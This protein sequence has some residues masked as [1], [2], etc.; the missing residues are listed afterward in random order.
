MK[1]SHLSL[2]NKKSHIFLLV[3]LIGSLLVLGGYFYYNHSAKILQQEKENELKAIAELKINQIVDWHKER[4]ADAKVISQSPFIID[5]IK[6]W[7]KNQNNK[8]LENEISIKLQAPQKEFGYEAIFLSSTAGKVLLTVGTGLEQFENINGKKI[9]ESVEKKKITFTDFYYCDIHQKIHNDLVTPLVD[10]TGKVIAVL[11]FRTDPSN[12]I[13]P[14]IQEWPIPS[15]SAETFLVKKDGDSV[16]SLSERRFYKNVALKLR[17]PLNKTEIPLVQAVLGTKG[18]YEGRSLMGIDVLSYLSPVPGTN[19]YLIAQID[20]NEMLAELKFRGISVIIFLVVLISSLTIGLVWIY[21]YR[22][23]NIYRTL[24][25]TQQEYKTTIHSIGDAVITTDKEGRVRFLNPVAEKLTGWSET[26]AFGKPLH[27][28]FNII[29]EVTRNKVENPVKK[30]LETGLIVGLANHTILISKDGNEIPITDS[31]APIRTESGEIF[32]VVL[33]FSDQT[34]ERLSRKILDIRLQLFEYAASH[35]LVELLT[36]TLDEVESL[37]KSQIGFFHFVDPDQETLSLQAWS[38]GTKNV[39]CKAAGEGLHYKISEA[40]VWVECV[41]QKK[42]VIHNDYAS[43]P[44]KKGLPE[45]HSPIVRELVV[46]ILRGDN[47]VA[48]LGMGNK[49]TEYIDKDVEIVNYFAD[50]CWEIVEQKRGAENIFHKNQILSAI[51]RAHDQFISTNGIKEVFDGLLSD[52]LSITKSG[53]GFIGEVLFNGEG[54]PY[55][56][57]HAISNISWNE[58]TQKFY[59]ENAAKGMEFYNLKTLFGEALETG[60]TLIANDPPNHPKRG[61]LPEGHPPLNSFLG[62]PI[63]SGG[64]LVAM[65][66]IANAPGGYTSEIIGYL[67]P[68]LGTIGQL[69]ETHHNVAKRKKAESALRE[70]E[71]KLRNIFEHSTNLFYSHDT[72]YNLQYFSPQVKDILGY[73]AE[74]AK[75]NWTEIIS[76][77]PINKIGFEKT[78]KA[79]ETGIQQE[80]YE[81]ELIHK[82]GHKVYVEVRE[83][84]VVENGKTVAIVGSLTDITERKKAQLKIDESEKRFRNVVEN[85]HEALIV[86]NT[87]GRV[88]YANNEFSNIFGYSKE[89]FLDLTSK[90]YTA[91]AS[92]EEVIERHRKRMSGVAV[93]EKFVYKGK[94][95]DGTEIWIEARVTELK[96]NGQIVGTQS[97]ERDITARKHAE[98]ELRTKLKNEQS[99]TSITVKAISVENLQQFLDNCIE[100]IGKSLEVDRVYLF[101]HRY[102][103]DTMDNTHEWCAE[104]ILPQ[105]E[106]LQGIPSI[107]VPWWMEQMRNNKLINFEDI[108]YLPDEGAK[109]SLREQGIRSIL[110]VPLYV[111]G[112]YFGFIGFDECK[113]NRKW[114]DSMI[115]FLQS[116]S[117][118]MMNV[119]ER[120]WAGEELKRSREQYERFFMEDLTG[121]FIFTHDG[122]ILTCNPSF[123]KIFGFTSMEEA[124]NINSISLFRSPQESEKLMS[125]LQRE[126]KLELYD[127]EMV[128]KDGTPL[129]IVANLLGYFDESD[130]LREVQGYVFDDTKRRKLE[131]TLIHTQKMESIG[132]LAGGIAHDFNNILGI[133][134]GHSSLLETNMNN[135]EKLLKC[136]DAINT[137]SVRGASLVK[138]LLTIARKSDTIVGTVQVNDIILEIKKLACET[139]SKTIEFDT[140]LD[141]QIPAIDADATQIHQVMINLCVNARDAMPSGGKLAISTSKVPGDI[142][143]QMYPQAIARDYVSIFVKDTGLGMPEDVRKRIF[144]PFFTTKGIGKGTGLGLS[145]VHSIIESHRGLIEVSSELGKGTEFHIYFPI[146]EKMMELKAEKQKIDEK[147]YEGDET[148]LII[149]D[150]ELLRELLKTILTRAGYQVLIAQDG[151]EGI[152]LY[153]NHQQNID[154][155]ISDLGLPKLAGDEVFRR[156]KKLHQNIKFILASGFIDKNLKSELYKSGVKCIIQKPFTAVE[157]LQ[158]IREV[159]D[160]KT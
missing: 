21:H 115:T 35:S 150:E 134:L 103:T 55:L 1:Q 104:G 15:K 97:L 62:L 120:N 14:L 19:W 49:S 50:V 45:G 40:G 42:P 125:R 17:V 66:G 24:W 107:A 54:Q 109:T 27:L 36:K 43:L 101:E 149:E 74:E 123:V 143:R 80:P 65:V 7:L 117:R 148:V 41:H 33:V 46:P 112:S 157:V 58:A 25:Q 79:I 57:T 146:P 152:S 105:K 85:I 156:I 47:V 68:L 72:N 145:L 158:N 90:D 135:P 138:Q 114:T 37:T 159:I 10:E 9:T 61:G 81:L 116:V 93:P 95:K 52:I 53:Y 127:I 75:I 70:S 102:E 4:I 31:G 119:I 6:D 141:K 5:A 128:K 76:D 63:R 121:D 73:T 69:V 2:L 129:Y 44:H 99:L 124:L 59:E 88:V 30:V 106:N 113:T 13:Y 78:L 28:V 108:E 22:Q 151:E 118:I 91:E 77:N 160:K 154:V 100:I 140:T 23:R 3:A 82:N 8:H 56:K 132:T 16:L 87:E 32:G 155:V 71:L 67:Q 122:S 84:P 51:K 139:F 144:E 136:I 34:E 133:I 94:R 60:E 126:R 11:V 38:T 64:K 98:E 131:E 48:I 29:N 89:E 83:A 142:L 12:N 130:K 26:E 111:K 18:I 96:E 39:F 20:R 92:Y 153:Y 137:A 86:E 147:I 110:V